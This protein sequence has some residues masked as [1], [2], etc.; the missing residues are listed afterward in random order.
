[1]IAEEITRELGGQWHGRYGTARCPAHE[2]HTPSLSLADSGDGRL[3]AHCFAGCTF[4]AIQDAL[5]AIGLIPGRYSWNPIRDPVVAAARRARARAEAERR[6]HFA[7]VAWDEA[8]PIRD[9]PAEIYL[10][11]RGID[12][13]LP[14]S[15]RYH[16]A[17]WHGPTKRCL[18]AVVARVDGGDG[19]AV[20]RTFLQSDGS[21]KA[22]VDP[23]KMMLGGTRGGAVHLSAAPGPLLVAEGIET[24][25]AAGI[26]LGRPA[27]VWA[28]LSTSGMTALILPPLA[29]ELILA[30]DGDRAGAFAARTLGERARLASWEVQWWQAPEGTDWNDVLRIERGVTA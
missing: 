13:T 11:G 15:L 10:R 27:G 16:P 22:N 4:T 24:A 29:G 17:C 19:P 18:P 23:V 3:L 7:Q 5:R 8:K 20:H 25:L 14:A 21:G 9:T 1:M 6:S 28:A 2:D 12:C 30:V 26:L